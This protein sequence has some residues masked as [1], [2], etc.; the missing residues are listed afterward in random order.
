MILAIRMAIVEHRPGKRPPH[1]GP[2]PGRPGAAASVLGDAREGLARLVALG[3]GGDEIG[4]YLESAFVARER[5]IRNGDFR[6]LDP[7]TVV[8]DYLLPRRE[9]YR[10]VAEGWIRLVFLPTLK[11]RLAEGALVFGLGRLFSSYNDMGIQRC[12]D[13]DLNIVLGDEARAA[14]L[15]LVYERLGELKA[16][17]RH[18]FGFNLEVNRDYTVSRAKDVVA[19]LTKGDP[20]ARSEARRFYKSNE[21]SIGIIQDSAEIR[22]RIF[23]PAR[24]EPDCRL[25]EHFL[26]LEGRRQSYAKLRSGL[27][28]LSLAAEGGAKASAAAVVGSKGF[29]AYCQRLFPRR[30]FLSPPDWVFSMKYFVNR[31]YDY[32]AAMRAAGHGLRE[33]GFDAP[34][35]ELGMDPDYRYLRDAHKLMLYLQEL[36]DI[37]MRSYSAESDY[38]YISRARFLGF[39]ELCGDKFKRDFD[40]MVLRGELL[41]QSETVQ[42]KL[43]RE[44]VRTKARDRFVT[45]RAADLAQYPPDFSY[46]L[47]YRDGHDFKICVPYSWADLGYFAFSAIASRIAKI[48]D[49]RLVPQLSGFGMPPEA[50]RMYAGRIFDAGGG[51]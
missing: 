48:V 49:E 23:A 24:G 1:R 44:K 26:G 38:S 10:F 51:R 35:E 31:V 42:Y 30:S 33:I 34:E 21:R 43:L 16:E 2:A 4:A 27:E 28:P 36:L 50:V 7:G 9:L 25:F 3:A 20:A 45:G 39:A 40:E 13:L 11:P 8:R 37:V 5:S 41:Y 17:L 46:E 14:D 47:V 15:D 32:V 12:T 6:L 29:D 19:R 22:E 18:R